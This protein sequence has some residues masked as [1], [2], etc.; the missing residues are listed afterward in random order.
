MAKFTGHT[1]TSDSALGSAVI[2]RSLRFNRNEGAHLTYTPASAS[3][4][5]TKIT[6]SAWVKKSGINVEQN[7]FHAG[8]TNNN[9]AMLRF[10]TSS[11]YDNLSFGART[12]GSWILQLQTTQKSRD[13]SAWYHIVARC[14]TT[15][16][17]ANI[18]INGEEVTSF[19]TSNK[20]S[21][22]QSLEWF[23]NSEHQIGERGYS[24]SSTYMD[25]YMA[26]VNAIQGQA[27]DASYFGFTDPQTGIWMPKRYEGTYGDGFYLDFSDNSSTAALG[28]D[29]SPNGNDFTANNFSVSAGD[30]NDSLEDSPTNNFCTYNPLDSNTGINFSQGNLVVNTSGG[31]DLAKSTFYLTSGKWYWEVTCDDTGNGFIGVSDQDDVLNNRGGG[32]ATSCTIRSTNGDKRISGSTSSYGSAVAD[33]DVMMFA[34]D[35]DNGKFWAG[36]NGTFFNSGDPAAGSNAATSALTNPVSPSVSLYD[37]EDYTVNFGQRPFTYTPPAGYKTLCTK[38]L[39]LTT[40]SIVRPQKHYDTILYTGQNTSSL[41]DVTGLEFAPDLVW[42]KTRTTSMD[43]IFIDTVRGNDKQLNCPDYSAEVTRGTPSYRFLKDGFAVGTG[44]NM[45]NPQNYAAWCWKAG[46]SSNTYNIDGTGYGTASAAGLDGGTI[47]PTGASVNTESGFAIFTYTGNGSAGSTIAHGLGKKP[48]W[49][50]IKRRDASDNWMVYHNKANGGVDP[51]D[52]YFELNAN[53]GDINA[54]TMLNDTAPTSTLITLGSD[55]SVNGNTATYVM[56]CWSEI[57]GFSKFGSYSGNSSSDGTYVHL[58]FRPAVLIFKKYSGSDSWEM[59]DST[60]TTYNG[61]LT[62]ALYPSA[63]STETTSG[64]EIDFLSNGFKQRNANGNTNESGHN[65]I[66]MAFAEEPGSTPFDTFPNA[67]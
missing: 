45:N 9:R 43:N 34:V 21:G 16:G 66:Y 24:P 39:P 50:M 10:Y 41:Y 37:N 1:I 12:S 35:M 11:G 56:Y 20:P 53:G 33:G 38:N 30:G 28:I 17:T 19:T 29:K 3:S 32:N 13:P 63:T 54:T 59:H 58:G 14:D 25:G 46:G 22:S 2:Q 62:A 47:D 23:N 55:N 61:P 27:L 49:I 8:T 60:R 67:R 15:N 18:Y 44:G 6:L 51:E 48:A 26:E 36:K 64:R 7:I 40:P 52:Y 31:F 65:Y 42:A 57:P 4:D 5:R